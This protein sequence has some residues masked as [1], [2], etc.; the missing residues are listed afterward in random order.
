MNNPF[1]ICPLASGSR[2]N[3]LFIST[4]DT[5]LLIDAGLSG[6]EIQRRMDQ[7][8]ENPQDLSAIIITHEHS[9]HI[10]GAGILSRRFKI[11]V[12]VTPH[13]YSAC[14]GLGKIDH[15]NH[16]ECGR[17]FEVGSIRINPFS[18]SHDARD[19]AGLTLTFQE[20]KIGVATDLGI[21]TGLVREHLKNSIALYLE[22]N[23]DPDML[24]N[25]PYPWHLKQRIRSRTGHLSNVD[26][27]NLV[28]EL[29]HQDLKHIIL[30]HLSE[31][32]NHP[33]KALLEVTKGLNGSETALYVASPDRPGQMIRL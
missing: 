18:I 26:A 23:H 5:A 17:P 7:V 21:V 31:E 1:C 30:A 13:T 19:P 32:N 2:G 3:S 15:L 22:S 33:Q 27:R 28:S 4:P 6:K 10:R 25:G 8:G 11:P 29:L 20:K 9:D 12:Y 24:I 14:Q 16:F